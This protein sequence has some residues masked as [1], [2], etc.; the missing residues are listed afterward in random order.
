LKGKSTIKLLV[1]EITAL[2]TTVVPLALW[3]FEDYS[4]ETVVVLYALE[5]VLAMILAALCVFITA[6]AQDFSFSDSRLPRRKSKTLKDFVLVGG[7]AT[8]VIL[9]FPAVFIFLFGEGRGVSFADVRFGFQI[10][11]CF[12]LFEFFSNL[13]LLR[14][15][16]LKQS[17]IFL[18]YSF[19]GMALILISM[20]LGVFLT[21]FFN[22]SPFVPFIILKTIS[23]IGQPIQYFLG[24][25]P[26]QTESLFDNVTVKNKI[27][28]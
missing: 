27:K 12:Q 8:L 18:S 2:G 25:T 9:A 21:V 15:L 1:S 14:P 11:V 5:S 7:L 23:D 16:S 3:Y 13:Y 24:Q 4:V 20:F 22:I 26:P 10:V 6:P 17:E 19:G 28:Y